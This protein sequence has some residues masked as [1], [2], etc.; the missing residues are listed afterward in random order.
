MGVVLEGSVHET[1]INSTANH[2]IS[3]KFL[4]IYSTDIIALYLG[5]IIC[6]KRCIKYRLVKTNSS[7]SKNQTV[8]LAYA[9]ITAIS[10]VYKVL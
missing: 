9:A 3:I 8:S 2:I 4:I 7:Q 1:T 5:Y 6:D 10:V